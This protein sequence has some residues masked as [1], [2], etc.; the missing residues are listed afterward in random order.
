MNEH[1]SGYASDAKH[2]QALTEQPIEIMQ[3]LFSPEQ[4]KGL[5]ARET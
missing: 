3:K 1:Y 2:Y 4:L 5:F